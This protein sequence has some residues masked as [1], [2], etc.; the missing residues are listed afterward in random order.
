MTE[1]QT[2]KKFIE[3]WNINDYEILTDDGFVDIKSLGKTIPYEVYLLETENGKKIKCADNHI[4]FDENFNEIFVK[5]LENETKIITDSGVSKVVNKIDLGYEEN[6]YDFQLCDDSKHRYYTN[7]ILSHNTL[8]AKTL[9]KEIFGDEKYLVRFDMSEYA[10]ETSVNKLI[11]AS[12]GYVGYTE[13]GL[14]T[15]A[16]KNKKYCVLLI[17]EIEKAHDKVYNLFLQI[18]DEGFLTD[19]TGYKVDFRNT[20]IIMTSNVGAK[21]AANTKNIGFSSDDSQTKEDVLKKELKNKFPPEFL[22]RLDDIIFFNPLTDDNLKAIIKIELGYLQKRVEGI[23]YELKYTDDVVD[24]L[25]N[26]I[27]D[28]KEYGARPIHRAIRDKIENKLTD[29]LIEEDYPLGKQFTVSVNE[30]KGLEIV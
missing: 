19:N 3:T 7:G 14:L 5:D 23:H 30:E 22:N 29:M 6:M 9:A 24:V 13:G 10:D 12:A 27:S 1:K 17:D 26:A 21:K 15:E 25:F 18:L 8:I 4:V 20:I 11:G 28:E 16:I 2:N